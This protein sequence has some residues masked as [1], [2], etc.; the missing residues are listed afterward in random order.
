M[1]VFKCPARQ[2]VWLGRY[3]CGSDRDC[4]PTDQLEARP[5]GELICA[6]LTAWNVPHESRYVEIWTQDAKRK[7]MTIRGRAGSAFWAGRCGSGPSATEV[8]SEAGPM[9]FTID[10]PGI[11]DIIKLPGLESGALRR[12]RFLRMKSA[13]SAIPEALQWIPHV[14]TKLDDAQDILSTGLALAIPLIKR[15]PTRVLPGVGWLLAA[16]DVLNLLT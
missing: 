11:A 8:G 3:R 9:P 14:L 4:I 6:A 2:Q 12:E 10:V 13:R 15:L 16:N 1:E 5:L 7:I